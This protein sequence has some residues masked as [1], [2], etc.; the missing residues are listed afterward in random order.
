VKLKYIHKALNTGRKRLKEAYEK[1]QIVKS[2]IPAELSSSDVSM[3][4]YDATNE[5]TI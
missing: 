3:I 2:S 4:D 5:V 1:I